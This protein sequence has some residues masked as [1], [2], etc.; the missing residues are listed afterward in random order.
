M[1]QI[2]IYHNPRCSKSRETLA[3]IRENGGEPEIREY[4]KEI[5]SKE[6]LKLVL[7]KLD[8]NI[9]DILRKG[10]KLYKDK[11]KGMNFTD[12]EW[13]TIVL[14]NPKLMERPI[15]IKGNKAILGRPPEN[16]LELL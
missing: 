4:L 15:V 8:L 2:T 9:K 5:P 3:L 1:S 14:E 13:M 6:E 12:E 16:V 10:E 7:A 11:F